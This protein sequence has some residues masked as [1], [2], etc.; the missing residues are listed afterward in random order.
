M[1]IP[2]NEV[3]LAGTYFQTAP[4]LRGALVWV[5]VGLL[6]LTVAHGAPQHNPVDQQ[7]RRDILLPPHVT[8]C[9]IKGPGTNDSAVSRYS[10]KL[11]ECPSHHC[12]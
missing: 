12:S 11:Q 4:H 9:Y 6:N 7:P 10:G 1:K 8:P 5:P 3:P 2:W